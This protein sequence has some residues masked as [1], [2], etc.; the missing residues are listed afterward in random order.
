MTYRQKVLQLDGVYKSVAL[1]QHLRQ[2]SKETE[3]MVKLS[4]KEALDKYKN[5]C[6][7]IKIIQILIK[8]L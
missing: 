6:I 1:K 4:Q 7:G 8:G 2:K 5:E 3:A